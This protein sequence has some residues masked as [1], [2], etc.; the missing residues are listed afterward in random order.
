MNSKLLLVY[1]KVKGLAYS[2]IP[3]D[4]CANIISMKLVILHGNGL[5][6]ISNRL[7]QIKKDF[8]PLSITEVN[9]KKQSLESVLAEISTPQLFSEQRLVILEDFDPALTGAGQS[10]E[11]LPHEDGLTVVL[12]FSKLLPSS[13][14]ILKEAVKLNA[15]V[16]A[17]TEKD[18]TPIFP[19]LD[20]LSDKKPLAFVQV[21]QLL[22]EYG[23][24]YLLA[25]IFFMLRRLINPPKNLPPFVIKKLEKQKQNFGG[26]KI[27][28]IY[29]AALETDF[30]IKK[31]LIEE[32]I[33]LTMLVQKILSV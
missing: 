6:G 17:L 29:Q 33:G 30:K 5:A 25:M 12:K 3:D 31:G 28:E 16:M 19:F 4:F 15:Q 10:L 9:G 21:D 18:E 22:K 32:K 1:I 27:T 24:Q 11:K 26:S 2:K 20:N 7:S 14:V 8:D 23:S 13:S